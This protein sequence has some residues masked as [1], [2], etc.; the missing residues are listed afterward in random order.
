MAF[1]HRIFHWYFYY[2]PF[3]CVLKILGCLILIGVKIK[4]FS[5]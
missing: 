3:S 1:F 4:C 5:R 2:L